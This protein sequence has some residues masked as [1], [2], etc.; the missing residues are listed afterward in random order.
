MLHVSFLIRHC[1]ETG[2]PRLRYDDQ[3][4]Q[5]HPLLLQTRHERR[6]TPQRRSSLL[7]RGLSSLL[8]SWL[9]RRLARRY[10]RLHCLSSQGGSSSK[11]GD[12][13]VREV[14]EGIDSR[15][16]G[17]ELSKDDEVLRVSGAELVSDVLENGF[18]VDGE[19]V[20][21]AQLSGEGG[22]TCEAK[23]RG[24]SR[25]APSSSL[26]AEGGLRLTLQP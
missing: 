13:G 8:D 25:S 1:E 20:A 14:G 2:V 18:M 26:R 23:G 4:W 9:G 22:E 7:D 21:T 24:T 6:R 15:H 11:S 10:C 5:Q 3:Q 19:V 16:G 17:E 12:L